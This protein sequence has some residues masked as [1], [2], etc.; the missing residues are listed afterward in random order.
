ML[1]Q[2]ARPNPGK[3]QVSKGKSIKAPVGGWELPDEGAAVDTSL[4]PFAATSTY[5]FASITTLPGF[6]ASHGKG[7]VTGLSGSSQDLLQA[8]PLSGS[9]LVQGTGW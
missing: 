6:E 4:S 2:A 3:V 7:R 8:H 9:F 1:R 5:P